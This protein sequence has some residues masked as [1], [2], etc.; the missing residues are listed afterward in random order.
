[1][2]QEN[3]E[4]QEPIIIINPIDKD[5]VAENP[6]LM[7][8]AHNVGG[9]VIKPTE[10]GQIKGKAMA[11]MEQQTTRQLK[12]LYEQMQTLAEQAKKL[13]DRA[14]ISR[15]IYEAEMSFEPVIGHIYYLYRR[16]NGVYIL[17]MVSPQEWGKSIPF[18]YISEV[19][20]LADHTWEVLDAHIDS[21]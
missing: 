11:A 12:Q 9:F 17:S 8:Y 18:Q 14:E 7:E 19:H 20:L 13:Q 15:Q 5:K 1:M 16:K 10:K 3:Q 4:N 6:G 2:S 21:L